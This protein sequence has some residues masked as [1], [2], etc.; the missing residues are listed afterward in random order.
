METEVS[1]MEV[2]FDTSQ[3]GG[4]HVSGP[5]GAPSHEHFAGSV[6]EHVIVEP[7]ASAVSARIIE[8]NVGSVYGD[9]VGVPDV[10]S[11]CTIHGAFV[12]RLSGRF[13]PKS[14]VGKFLPSCGNTR[15]YTQ[16]QVVFDLH[17]QRPLVLGLSVEDTIFSCAA[18]ALGAA[19]SDAT[20]SEGERIKMARRLETVVLSADSARRPSYERP[21]TV[22]SPSCLA[23]APV[24]SRI[25]CL[26]DT[27]IAVCVCASSHGSWHHAVG[28]ANAHPQTY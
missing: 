18:I 20:S 8:C 16:Y 6:G 26:V 12:G 15:V 4:V 5:I 17:R 14:L 7:A 25:A 10:G 21:P 9:F 11:V 2:L 24:G 28:F 22:E 1:K 23:S 13:G 19:W 27:C 3:V